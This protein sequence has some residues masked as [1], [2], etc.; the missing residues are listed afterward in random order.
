M[1]RQFN[2]FASGEDEKAVTHTILEVFGTVCLF[3]E[4]GTQEE[5]IA[6]PIL[7]ASELS[8]SSL[9]RL[10]FLANRGREDEIIFRETPSGLVRVDFQNS[11]VFEYSASVTVEPKTVKVGRVALFFEGDP[12]LNRS[13]RLLISRLEGKAT[14]LPKHAGFWIF[15][16][17]MHDAELLQ[18]WVGSPKRNPLKNTF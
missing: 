2:Y 6:R 11:P 5:M 1:S 14:Q 18:H 16:D 8:S 12:E 13:F 15:P 7:K 17:A 9:N 4:S 10:V 3:P